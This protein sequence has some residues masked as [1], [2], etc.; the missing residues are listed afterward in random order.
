MSE[1]RVEQL[2][3]QLHDFRRRAEACR[4]LT[5]MGEEA[6]GPLLEALG[7]EAQQGAR[8]AILNCLG[9]LRARD[10]VPAVAPYLEVPDCQTVAHDTLVKISGRDLGLMPEAWLK[11]AGKEKQPLPQA[12]VELSDLELM[13]GALQ[14]TDAEW[15][16][17]GENG[18]VVRLP[19]GAGESRPVYARFGGEDHEGAPIVI[20]YANCGEAEPDHYET[21]LRKNLNMPYGAIAIR[22]IR[23]IP[24]FVTFNTILRQAL[25]PT[26]L[27]KTI[28][29]V[30]EQA[31]RVQRD[32]GAKRQEHA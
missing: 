24:H 3:K 15:K 26:E 14:G 11:G 25:S 1:K 13:E 19:V 8:W 21:A 31:E 4:E 27:R 12:E 18:Y 6:I 9:D 2:I 28:L 30:G 5:G 22:D 32:L 17:H 10:A 20:V 23:G 16:K 7:N 29:T